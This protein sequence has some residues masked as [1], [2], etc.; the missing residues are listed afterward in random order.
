MNQNQ[1]Q[2]QQFFSA[3]ALYE[4]NSTISSS[5]SAGDAAALDVP[6]IGN[7]PITTIVSAYQDKASIYFRG[8]YQLYGKEEVISAQM[9]LAAIDSPNPYKASLTLQ[10]L[11]NIPIEI[12]VEPNSGIITAFRIVPGSVV[13][14]STVKLTSNGALA[15]VTL[16]TSA[17][18]ATV[19]R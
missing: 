6:Q 10:G 16:S 9:Q 19:K 3:A 7:N 12:G 11:P 17:V 15:S 5:L 18:S 2:N 4:I 13:T 8:N 1:N 14:G